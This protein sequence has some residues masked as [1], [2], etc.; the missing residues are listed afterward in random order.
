MASLAASHRSAGPYVSLPGPARPRGFAGCS[1]IVPVR[2]CADWQS[3]HLPSHRSAVEAFRARTGGEAHS[4]LDSEPHRRRFPLGGARGPRT[5]TAN[6]FLR[7]AFCVRLSLHLRL[8]EFRAVDGLRF[9]SL[10][11]LAAVGA[12]RAAQAS[13]RAVRADLHAHLGRSEEH[14]SELQSLMPISYAVFCLK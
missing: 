2:M 1:A 5:D 12:A 11:P 3:R 13:R 7:T 8:R 6:R 10:R 9:P 4:S 14:T